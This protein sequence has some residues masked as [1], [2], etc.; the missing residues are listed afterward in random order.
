MSI[1]G[2]VETCRLDLY[3]IPGSRHSNRFGWGGTLG[4]VP[5]EDALPAQIRKSFKQLKIKRNH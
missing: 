5:G 2:A 1:G 3:P 4:D